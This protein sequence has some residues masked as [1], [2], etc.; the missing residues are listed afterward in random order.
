MV[1]TNPRNIAEDIINNTDYGVIRTDYGDNPH[2]IRTDY[3]IT[4][5]DYGVIQG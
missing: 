3:G 5:T 2:G 4:P 1:A